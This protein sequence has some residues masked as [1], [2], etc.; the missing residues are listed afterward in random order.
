MLVR[1]VRNNIW[2]SLATARRVNSRAQLVGYISSR[3]GAPIGWHDH[4]IVVEGFGVFG[5]A[6]APSLAVAGEARRNEDE[7]FSEIKAAFAP[8]RQPRLQRRASATRAIPTTDPLP[9]AR[10]LKA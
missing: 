5:Y 10:A 8:A 6:N 2:E 1:E 3:L 4:V 9:I 7:Q